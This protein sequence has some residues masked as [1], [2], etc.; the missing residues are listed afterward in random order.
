MAGD[1]GAVRLIAIRLIPVWLAATRPAAL[2]LTVVRSS[3]RCGR[4]R[5][6]RLIARWQAGAGGPASG[7]PPG[8]DPAAAGHEGP[9]PALS[10]PRQGGHG[11]RES[12]RFRV[13]RVQR[14]ARVAGPEPEDR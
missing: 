5:S 9:R 1:F 11:D 8:R 3:G 14:P 6:H 4:R 10:R 13:T 12:Y 7:E 2:R